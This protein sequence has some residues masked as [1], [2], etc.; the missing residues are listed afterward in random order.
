MPRKAPSFA[1]RET[2]PPKVTPQGRLEAFTAD[3]RGIWWLAG[4]PRSYQPPIAWPGTCTMLRSQPLRRVRDM[5][6]RDVTSEQAGR[7]S[8][9][10]YPATS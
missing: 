5:T 2:S 6:R 10:L 8:E 4:P 7:I 3:S 9:A 1:T